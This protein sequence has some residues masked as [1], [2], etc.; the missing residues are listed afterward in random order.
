[1]DYR[2]P[3]LGLMQ[4][5]VPCVAPIKLFDRTAGHSGRNVQKQ[6]ARAP[7]A[8]VAGKRTWIKGL[9]FEWFGH[10]TSPVS[11]VGAFGYQ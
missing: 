4:E 11:R 9:L 5:A 6:Q 2:R 3:I 1:M 10:N 8:G 7:L